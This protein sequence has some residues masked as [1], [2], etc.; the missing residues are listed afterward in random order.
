MSV[1]QI[2]CDLSC[3]DIYPTQEEYIQAFRDFIGQSERTVTWES[4]EKKLGDSTTTEGVILND[5]DPKIDTIQLAGHVNRRNAWQVAHA[6][7]MVTSSSV[8][9]LLALLEQFPG[10]SRRF[11]KIIPSLYSDYAHTPE[12]IRQE[13]VI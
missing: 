4:D 9:S 10:V 6:L 11:E 12:K 7:H 1:H 8:E 3:P 2:Y 13:S 5:D